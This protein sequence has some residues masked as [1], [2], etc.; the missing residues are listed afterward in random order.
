M[1]SVRAALPSDA[2]AMSAL[3]NEVIAAGG[4]TAHQRPFE[5]SPDAAP[6]HR[7]GRA[8]RMHGRRDGRQDRGVSMPR[9][10]KRRRRSVSRSWA[11]IATFAQVGMTGSGIGTALFAATKAMAARAGVRTIDATIRAD[12]T[13]GL[14]YYAKMGFRDYDRLTSVPLRDGTPVDRI[15][16]RFDLARYGVS[17][18]CA[19]RGS[20]AT[21][22]GA[23]SGAAPFR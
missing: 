23:C 13:G 7:A 11:I 4:T 14:R 19:W 2:L 12:N 21:S 5:R 6:L 16:K 9:L 10:A 18:G 17:A 22:V 8:G 15:R 20:A 1:T 3:L